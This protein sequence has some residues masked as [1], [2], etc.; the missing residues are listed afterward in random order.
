[1]KVREYVK[2]TDDLRVLVYYVVIYVFNINK[3]VRFHKK[4]LELTIFLDYES[5]GTEKKEYRFTILAKINIKNY[6]SKANSTFKQNM[7]I[8]LQN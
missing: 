2:T 3:V 6:Y 8:I 5:E 1:M 4:I 7:S